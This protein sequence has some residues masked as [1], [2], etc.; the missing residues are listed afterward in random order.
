MGRPK[1]NTPARFWSKVNVQSPD[2]CWEWQAGMLKVGYGKFSMRTNG[3]RS[4]VSAHRFAY[5]LHYGVL[6]GDHHVCHTCDNR[7]C[8][9]PAHLFL[10]THKDNMADM[11]SKDRAARGPHQHLAKL[12]EDDVRVIRNMACFESNTHVAKQFGI[13]VSSVG[14][15]LSGKTWGW[16]K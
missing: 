8:V 12:T 4:T 16:L 9:N 5:E 1:Q 6:P 10:G 15:I 13:C 11:A 3:V 14:N 7:K 2:D